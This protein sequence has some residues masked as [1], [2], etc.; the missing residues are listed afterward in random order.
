MV[1]KKLHGRALS[2]ERRSIPDVWSANNYCDKEAYRACVNP[3]LRDIATRVGFS[4]RFPPGVTRSVTKM[5]VN[6][7]SERVG[8]HPDC[9]SAL[10]TEFPGGELCMPADIIFL[11]PTLPFGWSASPGH[12]QASAQL[13]TRLRRMRRPVSP[14][15]GNLTCASHMFADDAM[16]G[17]VDLSHR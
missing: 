7:A 9:V 2:A 8:T 15:V 12:F 14:L 5:D 6:G 3:T 11:R 4:D 16:I 17:D 13:T 1:R 10:R